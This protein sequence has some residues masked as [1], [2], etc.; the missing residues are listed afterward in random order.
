MAPLPDLSLEI[1]AQVLALTTEP[2]A[3]MTCSDWKCKLYESLHLGS[4]ARFNV[5]LQTK[6]KVMFRYSAVRPLG[7]D[8]EESVSY[9]FNFQPDGNYRMQWARTFGM[10]S[11]WSE[12]HLGSWRVVLDQVFCE[13]LD[14]REEQNDREV[15]YAPAG[16]KFQLPLEGI[17]EADGRYYLAPPGSLAASWELTARTGKRDVPMYEVPLACVG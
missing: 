17:L 9:I 2:R 7:Q 3:S 15:P 1:Q 11:S 16:Y 5:R 8:F 12:Q 13:T 6:G 10:C 14:A 4:R